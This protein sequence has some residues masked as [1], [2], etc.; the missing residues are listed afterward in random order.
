[1]SKTLRFELNTPVEVALQAEDGVTVAG[2]YG[3]NV[4]PYMATTTA[5]FDR[6]GSTALVV[7]FASYSWPRSS[8][9]FQSQ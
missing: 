7:A 5:F 6:R 8:I 3:T 9:T 4:F 1:M 2:R